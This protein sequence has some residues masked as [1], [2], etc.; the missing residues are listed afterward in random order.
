M[1]LLGHF[2]TDQSYLLHSGTAI[3]SST[4]TSS[5]ISPLNS[6]NLAGFYAKHNKSCYEDWRWEQWTL[7]T[8]MT[9][10][11][12]SAYSVGVFFVSICIYKKKMQNKK[13][14]SPLLDIWPWRK[15]S[16]LP[17]LSRTPT[18]VRSA[19]RSPSIQRMEI[20]TEP[21]Y[22]Q[23]SPVIQRSPSVDTYHSTISNFN[24]M[25]QRPPHFI[26]Y[27]LQD[28]RVGLEPISERYYGDL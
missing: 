28:R 7:Y 20:E 23:L 19:H 12:I 13:S 1:G 14:E 16:D 10:I 18:L 25:Q 2:S 21:T 8:C 17:T 11:L 9:L 26:A 15:E 27:G 24:R 6:S 3:P 4:A 5:P 22:I